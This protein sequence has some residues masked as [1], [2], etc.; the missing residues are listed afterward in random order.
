MNREPHVP[1][2]ARN[3]LVAEAIVIGIVTCLFGLYVTQ[4]SIVLLQSGYGKV[5]WQALLEGLMTVLVGI[6]LVCL[7]VYFIGRSR[8]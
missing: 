2:V 6:I 8:K 7:P 3:L 1:W 4:F 5:A